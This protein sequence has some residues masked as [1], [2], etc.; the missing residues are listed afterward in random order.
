MQKVGQEE[1]GG[2][3]RVKGGWEGWPDVWLLKALFGVRPD[4]FDTSVLGA[5]EYCRCHL[6]LQYVNYIIV[7]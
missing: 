7:K 5:I 1:E 2:G 4:D 3:R 6:I